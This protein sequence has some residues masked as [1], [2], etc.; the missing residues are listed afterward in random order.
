MLDSCLHDLTPQET[1]QVRVTVRAGLVKRVR[2][3]STASTC[4]GLGT[5]SVSRAE[6]CAAERCLCVTAVPGSTES[7]QSRRIQHKVFE[8]RHG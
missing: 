3:R 6:R 2:V 8:K 7:V 1:S 5:L 4:S